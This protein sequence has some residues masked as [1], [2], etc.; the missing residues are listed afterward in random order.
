[1]CKSLGVLLKHADFLIHPMESLS[2]YF[3]GQTS[4]EATLGEMHFSTETAMAYSLCFPSTE[5]FLACCDSVLTHLS[6][7]KVSIFH[8][9][10][11][12]ETFSKDALFPFF[13]SLIRV[14]L[15]YS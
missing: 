8:F 14:V 1:M 5:V 7:Y 12:S 15:K 9:V 4:A 2:Q 3:C 13:F 6:S 11:L 10:S